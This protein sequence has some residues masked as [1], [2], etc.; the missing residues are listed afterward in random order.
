ML[1]NV[2]LGR[3]A[4]R[5]SMLTPDEL[6]GFYT[7]NSIITASGFRIKGSGLVL[8]THILQND[9]QWWLGTDW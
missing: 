3:V 9:L 5:R 1:S 2:S 6:I 8:K 7:R 4:Q